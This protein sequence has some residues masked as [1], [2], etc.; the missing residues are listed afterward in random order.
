MQLKADM[1]LLLYFVVLGHTRVK[2]AVKSSYAT[3]TVH[4]R[5]SVTQ[6][7][8]MDVKADMLLLV[9]CRRVGSYLD[10]TGGCWRRCSRTRRSDHHR[11]Q[12]EGGLGTTNAVLFAVIVVVVVVV[13]VLALVTVVVTVEI[14]VQAVAGVKE[15]G[16]GGLSPMDLWEH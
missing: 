12:S 5:T 9:H 16:V 10:R 2:D 1:L 6:E 4:C 8:K 3:T 13:T 7:L 14:V 15:V 11:N